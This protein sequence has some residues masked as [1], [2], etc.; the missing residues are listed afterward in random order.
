MAEQV[1]QR[2]WCSLVVHGEERRATDRVGSIGRFCVGGAEGEERE[3]EVAA[4]AASRARA[5]AR[6][7]AWNSL[8]ICV[9]D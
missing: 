4:E 3:A 8:V 2:D 1:V 9:S 6:A 5:S 7:A